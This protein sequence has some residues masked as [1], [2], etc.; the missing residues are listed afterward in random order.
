M[1][2]LLAAFR[3]GSP[4]KSPKK[5]SPTRPKSQAGSIFS[6]KSLLG[7]SPPKYGGYECDG[8]LDLPTIRKPESAM[9]SRTELQLSSR[10]GIWLK[11]ERVQ[12]RRDELLAFQEM[13]AM[14]PGPVLE[15]DAA[16][17]IWGRHSS[18]QMTGQQE[19]LSAGEVDRGLRPLVLQDQRKRPATHWDIDPFSLEVWW[20]A[21]QPADSISSCTPSAASS[22]TKQSRRPSWRTAD[23]FS[24]LSTIK[25]VFDELSP[26]PEEEDDYRA[27]L[28]SDRGCDRHSIDDDLESLLGYDLSR[29]PMPASFGQPHSSM[30]EPAHQNS[31]MRSDAVSPMARPRNPQIGGRTRDREQLSTSATQPPQLK[32]RGAELARYTAPPK[33]PA[34]K[35]KAAIVVSEVTAVRSSRGG[36]EL[37]RQTSQRSYY[38]YLGDDGWE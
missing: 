12:L 32:R 38:D 11:I 24:A 5:S 6:L 35:A 36:S 10:K 22:G 28:P 3:S 26:H 37:K 2:A 29:P 33:R 13:R 16:V 27:G 4:P 9:L 21:F 14:A 15:R 31:L 20:V 7:C 8:E 18:R 1:S 19:Q 23:N 17:F 25:P 30:Q 34:A